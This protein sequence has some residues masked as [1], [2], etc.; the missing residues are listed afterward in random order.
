[1]RLFY[2]LAFLSLS[3]I[4]TAQF[5]FPFSYQNKKGL[6]DLDG[7]VILEPTYQYITFFENQQFNKYSLFFDQNTKAS[8]IIN[9]QGEVVIEA[10]YSRL[11][12]D[13]NGAYC[14]YYD[15][16][17]N[18]KGLHIL[19]LDTGKEIYQSDS[20]RFEKV[21]GQKSFFPVVEDQQT[22][23]SY[24]LNKSGKVIAE[25][26][27]SFEPKMKYADEECPLIWASA[28]YRGQK[29]LY[30]ECDGTP[31]SLTA[32]ENK[33]DIEDMPIFEDMSIDDP[34]EMADYTLEKAQVTWPDYEVTKVV[35]HNKN[36][37][38]IIAK[39]DG[40]YGLL[41]LSKR[42]GVLLPFEYDR[43][44]PFINYITTHKGPLKGLATLKGRVVIPTKFVNAEGFSNVK[45]HGSVRT[46]TGYQG[47][48]NL[49]S[50]KIYLPAE[51]LESLKD[52]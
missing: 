19:A 21:L 52:L 11:H 48:V 27:S 26:S 37:Y 47:F 29:S 35:V 49:R 3:T 6:V 10:K 18:W 16:D 23:I 7:K 5:V 9:H 41:S 43:L 34:M 36:A 42:E 46:H 8:G 44:T 25:I 1:M 24:V 2:L 17:P 45:A 30:F 4:A 39:K 33:Y 14:W 20:L 28:N 32:Y 38:S 50:G 13:Q 40:K 15:D 51:V 22:S 31:T 12:Y